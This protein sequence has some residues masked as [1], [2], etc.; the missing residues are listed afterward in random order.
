MLYTT[1]AWWALEDRVMVVLKKLKSV[2]EESWGSGKLEEMQFRAK[3]EWFV[4]RQR[5]VIFIVM[6]GGKGK[7]RYLDTVS[8]LVQWQSVQWNITDSLISSFYK[9]GWCNLLKVNDKVAHLEIC[10]GWHRLDW[11]DEEHTALGAKFSIDFLIYRRYQVVNL[12][13]Y[14]Q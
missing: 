8:L 10:R 4:D 7:R 14:V 3:M 2:E 1:L 13:D 6:I 5:V 9:L 11:V 12:N